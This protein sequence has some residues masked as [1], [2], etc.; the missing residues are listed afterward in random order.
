MAT[1]GAIGSTLEKNLLIYNLQT[2]E[3]LE[4]G[5]FPVKE[6]RYFSGDVR[7][8]LHPRWNRTGN[9]IYIDALETRNWTRQLHVATLQF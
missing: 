1:D 4:L 7:C 3:G 2:K 5:R 6:K 9:A 8:D